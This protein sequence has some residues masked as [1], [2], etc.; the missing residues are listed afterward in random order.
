M[1]C[2]SNIWAQPKI[3]KQSKQLTVH[4]KDLE[5]AAIVTVI[6]GQTGHLTGRTNTV[7]SSS[8]DGWFGTD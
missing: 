7:S 3:A 8:S 5:A 2:V 6:P 1:R 4:I